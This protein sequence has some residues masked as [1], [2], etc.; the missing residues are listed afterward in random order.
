MQ[1]QKKTDP[2]VKFST[3]LKEIRAC[4]TVGVTQRRE[5]FAGFTGPR[6]GAHEHQP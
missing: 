5:F 6:K 2:H 4:V 1:G 3:T